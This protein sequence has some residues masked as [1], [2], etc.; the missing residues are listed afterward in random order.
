MNMRY[1][2]LLF[3]IFGNLY[4]INISLNETIDVSDIDNID[5]IYAHDNEIFIAFDV[6]SSIWRYEI[7]YEENELEKIRSFGEF[8]GIKDIYIYNET[9]YIL[10]NSYVYKINYKTRKELFK[11]NSDSYF[12]EGPHAITINNN[13]EYIYLIDR[14]NERINILHEYDKNKYLSKGSISMSTHGIAAYFEDIYDFEIYEDKMYVL[15]KGLQQITVF[16]SEEPYEYLNV[17]ASGRTGYSSKRPTKIEIDELFV[18]ILEDSN[19]IITLMDKESGEKIFEIENECENEIYD[20]AYDNNRIYILC[21]DKEDLMIY[22][23]DKRITKTKEQVENLLETINDKIKISCELYNASLYF[24]ANAQNKC[25]EFLNR[26]HN[27]TYD[28][29]NDAFDELTIIEASVTGYNSGV[30]PKLNNKIESNVSYYMDEMLSETPYEGTRNHTATRIIWD[31]QEILEHKNNNEYLSAIEKSEIAIRR[32]NDFI[33]YNNTEIEEGEKE[34]KNDSEDEK[35]N[36][37]ELI[38]I[39]NEFEYYKPLLENYTIFEMDIFRIEEMILEVENNETDIQE[40]EEEFNDIKETYH[41]YKENYDNA[42]EKIIEV[43]EKYQEIKNNLLVN[44]QEIELELTSAKE[45]LE[46]NPKNALVN[47]ENAEKLIQEEKSKSE[48]YMFLGLFGIGF[49]IVGF[50]VLILVG[51]GLFKY[52]KKK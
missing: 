37:I 41:E 34:E 31:L 36:D 13:G 6:E 50:I 48:N 27:Y 42:N 23:I 35:E 9:A 5:K 33:N 45:N 24:N 49:I 47:L 17:L 16:T 26:T 43:E 14:E 20:F 7:N 19:E 21:E 22:D 29:C 51:I 44:T 12:P 30:I 15:D 11:D 1:L 46:T 32:Y 3:L 10:D 28:N 18:Y 52:L 4:A 40:L 8:N 2:I 39:L 38:E 25:E